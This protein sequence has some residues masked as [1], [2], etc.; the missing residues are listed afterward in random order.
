MWLVY[1]DLHD[2]HDFRR[3]VRDVFFSTGGQAEVSGGAARAHSWRGGE[4]VGG[5]A[6][7]VDVI[8]K[9]EEA[10]EV[11]ETGSGSRSGRRKTKREQSYPE[12]V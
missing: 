7:Q 3:F 1:A 12:Q 10:E 5:R 11:E 4:E 9:A 8:T 6:E 2:L